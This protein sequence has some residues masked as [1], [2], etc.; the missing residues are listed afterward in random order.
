MPRSTLLFLAIATGIGR[1][2]AQSAAACSKF[3]ELRLYRE[4]DSSCAQMLTAASDG[5]TLTPIR[6]VF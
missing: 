4:L 5:K 2:A 3:E 6:F 1:C